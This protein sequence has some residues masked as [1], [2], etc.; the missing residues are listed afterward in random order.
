[1]HLNALKYTAWSNFKSILTGIIDSVAPRKKVRIKQ[2]TEQWMTSSILD[3][4]RLRDNISHLIKKDNHD[5]SFS[6]FASLRNSIQKEIKKAKINYF[7]NKLDENMGE[8]RILWKYLKNLGYSAKSNSKAKI[9]LNI[10]GSL[11]PDTLSV[12]KHINTFFTSVANVLTNK[13]PLVSNEY[14][15]G[16]DTFERFYPSKGVESIN[17]ELKHVDNDFIFG[18]LSKLN[19]HKAVGLDDI[20]PRFLRDGATHLSPIIAHIVNLSI[21]SSTVPHDLKLAK[22]IPLFKKNSR[23]EVGNYR[24]VSLLSTISKILEKSIYVQLDHYLSTNKLLYEFQSGFRPGFSTETCL[25]FLTDYI[26]SQLDEGK[27]VGMLLLDVQK[28]FDSVNHEILCHK[29]EAMGI[30]SAWFKSYLSN[31]RQLVQVDG[32]QSDLMQLSCGVPQGSL[33]GPLLYLIYSN[34]M[35]TSVKNLLLLYADDSVIISAD[36]NP[37]VVAR[38]LGLDLDS[39]NT[40]LINNKLSLHVDKTELILFGS[41]IH[42]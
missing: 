30:K 18:E 40:W 15:V 9:V 8:P 28:A 26:R 2:R 7:K 12:C 24:P 27:Y 13:L 38:D 35:V 42:P 10:D 32:I 29:L 16:S 36:K 19:I 4:I 20:A 3:K 23:L 34:D 33:L 41:R 6:H 25:I 1:M 22:V 31:R 5:V 14:G 11:Q 21:G 17:F 37:D 39:C